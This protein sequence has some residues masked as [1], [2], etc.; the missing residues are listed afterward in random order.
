MYFKV[1]D[2]PVRIAANYHVAAERNIKISFRID[3]TQAMLRHDSEEI[4]VRVDA[5]TPEVI[6]DNN[7]HSGVEVQDLQ[8][9]NL[10]VDIQQESWIDTVATDA[11]RVQFEQALA[12]N[13]DDVH[14]R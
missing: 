9:R 5:E 14:V 10:T 2:Q 4:N 13:L 6:V 3:I 7:L 8:N 12:I 1:T 11:R